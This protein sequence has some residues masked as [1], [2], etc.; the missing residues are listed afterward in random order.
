[1]AKDEY[2]I[3][4]IRKIYNPDDEEK[5]CIKYVYDDRYEAMKSSEDRVQAEK[6]W[7][8]AEKQWE[9]WREVKGKD[10]W[11]SN[12]VTQETFSVVE[13]ALSEIVK[14]NVKPIILPRGKEDE[15]RARVMSYI[16]DYA[17]EISDSDTAVYNIVKDALMFGTGIGQEYYLKDRRMVGGIS[18][19]D[20]N[21]EEYSEH[22]IF[23]Y[24]DV[25]LE[26]VKLQDFFVDEKAR[27]FS[28]P[29]AARDCIRR[30]IMNIEDFKLFFQGDVWD[31]LNNAQYVKAGGDTNF[32]EFYQPP[33][34]IDTSKEVEVLWYWSVKPKDRLII[35]AN[36]V[37]IVDRPNPYKHKQLPFVRCLDVK[38]VHRF[39]GK[40]EPEILESIHDEATTLRRMIIDRNHL[41]IDKMFFVSRQ[42]ALDDEDLIARPHGMIPTDDVAN[43]KAVEYGDIPRSV[44]LS[45]KYLE[46][47][48]TIATGIN[49]RA[50]AM[51]TAGTATEAAILKESTLRRIELKLWLMKKEF[52]VQM[53]RLR[54]ANI[55]QFYPQPKLEKIVGEQ[56]S[57]AFKDE[58][59]RLKERGLVTEMGKDKYKKEFRQI[60]MDGAQFDFGDKGQMQEQQLPGGSFS[61]F[62]LKPDYFVPVS[63]GGY[64]I[65]F[66][67]QSTIE[68]SKPL[69]Q[70]KMLELFDRFSQ[71]ALQVPGTYDI[72]KLGD[73]VLR[74]YDKDPNDLKPDEVVANEQTQFLQTLVELAAMENQ[75]MIQGK[76]VPPTPNASPVHSRAHI[77]FMMS[78]QFQ[79]LTND[80]PI[81][82]I[83]T[84]HVMGEI[85]AQ[86]MRQQIGGVGAPPPGEAQN[87][88]QSGEMGPT[89]Q[90]GISN[91]VTNRPG[92]MAKPAISN[93]NVRPAFN[94][95]GN[96]R[97]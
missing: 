54:V 56:N 57:Q 22:E 37:L 63:R 64:D 78:P 36:D 32:Y 30:I 11:Q 82:K 94:T 81:I 3:A 80:S 68:I 83:F 16:W 1:M 6:M 73:A 60:R 72:V 95:G 19:N 91:G 40:G 88:Q 71:I 24:D 55:L 7:D 75:M 65:K 61:F 5:E 38:R 14:Q 51:P 44:E 79:G 59:A 48:A 21:K 35:V 53:A 26:S 85:L 58:M 76:P 45:L 50:Q 96:A 27:G 34:G 52:L 92:G 84:D 9:A 10:N 69:M 23:A 31:P 47:D 2:K 46:D 97:R 74:S 62:E 29:F 25:I 8:K 41:D 17:W 42:A 15:A 93:Q 20:D 70:S 89:N 77:E 90:G 67:A 28:G 87:P 66:D 12:H 4:E 39:Y 18:V 33:K 13:T 86:Q 49:P 43:A